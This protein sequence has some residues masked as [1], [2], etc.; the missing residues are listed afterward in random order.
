MD[1]DG[2]LIEKGKERLA[3]LISSLEKARTRIIIPAPALS[4]LLVR[5]GATASQ[6]IV[7]EIGKASVFR[8]EAFDALAAIELATMT[9]EALRTRDKKGGVQDP[10][11]KV[12]FDKQIVAI[13]KVHQASAIYSDD[14]GVKTHAEKMGMSVIRIIDLPSPP[15]NPQGNLFDRVK[16]E[17]PDEAAIAEIEKQIAEAES[18]SEL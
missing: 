3:L 13:A 16:L 14:K 6:Q 15:E 10:W 4:E 7:E 18:P 8:I 5:A 1:S 9:R 17:S 2:K 11:A 12:K